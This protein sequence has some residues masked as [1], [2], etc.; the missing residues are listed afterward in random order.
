MEDR[1]LS[2]DSAEYAEIVAEV[3]AETMKECAGRLVCGGPDT[4]IT[5]A[6]MECLQY[7]YLHGA[8]PVREI[9]AGLEISLSAASQL[10]DRLVK[11]GL[12]TRG[13]NEQDRRLTSIDLTARGYEAVRKMRRA[14]SE[15]FDA[16][17][18]AMPH[19]QRR[20]FREGLEGFLKVALSGEDNVDRACVR[21]GREHVAF[22]VVNKIKNKRVAARSQRRE[23]LK[24]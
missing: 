12:A 23:E 24:P 13:E 3:F 16:I 2:R 19:S 20:A 15:W 8:S 1:H 14:K 7:I 17:I 6:L 4:D 11:K 21:C 10:V 5:P 18:Q 22:C 9:A